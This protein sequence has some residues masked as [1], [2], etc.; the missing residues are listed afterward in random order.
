MLDKILGL[1]GLD[2]LVRILAQHL[3]DRQRQRLNRKQGQED[4]GHDQSNQFWISFDHGCRLLYCFL[5]ILSFT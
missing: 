4:H 2:R 3:G 1:L 5:F